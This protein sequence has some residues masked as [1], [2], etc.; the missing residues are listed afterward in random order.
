MCMCVFI[1]INN[2]TLIKAIQLYKELGWLIDFLL[3][4]KLIH[5]Y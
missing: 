2:V 5:Q 4:S 3:L 1:N